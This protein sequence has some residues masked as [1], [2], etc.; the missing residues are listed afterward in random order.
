MHIYVHFI[1]IGFLRVWITSHAQTEKWND[2]G[3]VLFYLFYVLFHLCIRIKKKTFFSVFFLFA[4]CAHFLAPE[5]IAFHVIWMKIMGATFAG[6]TNIFLLLECYAYETNSAVFLVCN[7]V[8]FTPFA[9][10]FK[11]EINLWIIILYCPGRSV[12]SFLFTFCDYLLVFFFFCCRTTNL[13]CALRY[14]RLD[15]DM[16][17]FGLLCAVYTIW[18]NI[19][20]VSGIL[21]LWLWLLF[22]IINI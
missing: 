18:F 8:S 20:K 7:F 14:A 22:I 6:H 16:C 19:N 17:V 15:N 2:A 5:L 3:C 4:C 9:F 1:I 10:K 13:L 11:F 21:W 12:G